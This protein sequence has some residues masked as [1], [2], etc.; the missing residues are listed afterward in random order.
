VCC[1]SAA[2]TERLEC[3]AQG[4]CRF[5]CREC[6]K[7]FNGRSAGLLNRTQFPS[8]VIGSV[9]LGVVRRGAGALIVLLAAFTAAEAPIALGGALRPLGHR[10]RAAGHTHSIPVPHPV[11]PRAGA[12]QPYPAGQ[13]DRLVRYLTEPHR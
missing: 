6:G 1:G 3:A 11:G 8:D 2:L 4:Y 9:V 5:R 10:N 13:T 7:Q 12:Y